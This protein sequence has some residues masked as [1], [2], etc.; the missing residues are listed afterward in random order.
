MC[1]PSLTNI[2]LLLLRELQVIEGVEVKIADDGEILAKGPNIM[3]GYFKDEKQTK[4]VIDEDGWFHTGDIG[5]FLSD[6]SIR[7]V[8]RKKNLVKLIIKSNK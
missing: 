1:S 5:Q 2:L 8:D 4:E 7:I 3:M 6:G